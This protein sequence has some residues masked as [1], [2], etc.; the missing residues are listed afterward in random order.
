MFSYTDIKQS[1]WF[2]VNADIKKHARSNC[3][4]H[5]LSMIDYQEI[6]YDKI[7][8]PPTQENDNYVRPPMNEQTFV[9]DI[10][11]TMVGD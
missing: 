4:S 3:M 11:A 1:P 7:T 6:D 9:P 5:L 8:L 2:V 10:A